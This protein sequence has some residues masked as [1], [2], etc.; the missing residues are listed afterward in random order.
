VEKNDVVIEKKNKGSQKFENSDL[1]DFVTKFMAQKVKS[2]EKKKHRNLDKNYKDVKKGME[3]IK[4][5][6]VY[7]LTVDLKS[8]VILICDI[9]SRSYPCLL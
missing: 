8:E 1:N 3:F 7:F 2:M 6:C 5:K 9:K 4:W